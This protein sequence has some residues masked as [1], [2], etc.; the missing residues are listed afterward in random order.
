MVSIATFLIYFFIN[1]SDESIDFSFSNGA[2]QHL[3]FSCL[4]NVTLSPYQG[5]LSP[6]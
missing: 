6:E 3:G 1:P 2:F 4:N 5:D